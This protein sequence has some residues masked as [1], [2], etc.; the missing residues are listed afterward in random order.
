MK[1]S[2][3]ATV[4]FSAMGCYFLFLSINGIRSGVASFR[5]SGPIYRDK[6]PVAFWFSVIFYACAALA[7]FG[8]VAFDL[9]TGRSTIY[10]LS[11]K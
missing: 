10:P 7:A 8:Y 3:V 6:N 4:F 2:R 5:S 1:L 11:F 9:I